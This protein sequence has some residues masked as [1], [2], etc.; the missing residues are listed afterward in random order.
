MDRCKQIFHESDSRWLPDST[1]I[2]RYVPLRTLFFYLS[3]LVFI[4]SIAKLRKEEPFEGEFYEDATWFNDALA[5]QFGEE[6]I[7]VEDWIFKNLC[8]EFD[9]QY[10]KNNKSY[11][12]AA[13]EVYQQHYFDFVRRTRFAWCWFRSERESAAMWSVYGSQG[14]AIQSTIAKVKSILSQTGRDFIYARMTY[15]DYQSS[16]VSYEFN[17]EDD[18][19]HV[20]LLRPY[21]LK[22]KEYESEEEVRFITAGPEKKTRGGILLENVQP[23]QWISAIR[24][25]PKLTSREAESLKAPIRRV[26]P[27]VDC[28]KSDLFSRRYEDGP[29]IGNVRLTLEKSTEGHWQQGTDGIP[30]KAKEV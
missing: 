1:R 6:A 29:F 7:T 11:P 27:E 26:H 22:R 9:R 30:P 17:P 3:G 20:L 28:L 15:V 16:N 25:W 5:K 12:N 10:I 21:L 8:S 2:W 14:I 24:L 13:A 18:G 23:E 4:P 19:D